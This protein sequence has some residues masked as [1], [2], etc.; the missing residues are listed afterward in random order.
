MFC[1]SIAGVYMYR[2]GESVSV[3]AKTSLFGSLIM[4]YSGHLFNAR[5]SE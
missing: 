2:K 5:F 4:G 3:V 1:D